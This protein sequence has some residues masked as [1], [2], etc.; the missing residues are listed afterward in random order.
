MGQDRERRLAYYGQVKVKRG[1][2]S[3]RQLVDEVKRQW[4]AR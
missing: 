1:E 2:Q 4:Q 3:M